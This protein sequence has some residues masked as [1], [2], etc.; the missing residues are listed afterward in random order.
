M[1]RVNDY[2]I[3]KNR[4]KDGQVLLIDVNV[5]N[6]VMKTK[7]KQGPVDTIVASVP[8]DKCNSRLENW[9]KLL[10]NKHGDK[11]KIRVLSDKD[12]TIRRVD[13]FVLETDTQDW[14]SEPVNWKGSGWVVF[15]CDLEG[16]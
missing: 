16:V 10:N 8:L 2:V 13:M 7:V 14:D 12:N 11:R 5:Q 15:F 9:R 6:I 1:I 4:G 3:T